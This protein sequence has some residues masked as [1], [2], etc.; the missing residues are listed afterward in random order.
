[1]R[2]RVCV[3]NMQVRESNMQVRELVLCVHVCVSNTTCC[4]F[5]IYYSNSSQMYTLVLQLW[6]C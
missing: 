6:W 4:T 3:S 5:E 1:M 2:A